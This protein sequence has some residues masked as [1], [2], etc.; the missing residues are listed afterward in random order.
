MQEPAP[1]N[2]G[3]LASEMVALILVPTKSRRP[4][5]AVTFPVG[6]H[7]GSEHRWDSRWTEQPLGRTSRRLHS[8]TGGLL[9][10]LSG[11]GSR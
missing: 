4:E 6:K 8:S 1:L 2:S 5:K 11:S 10:S 9:H 7:S 3:I